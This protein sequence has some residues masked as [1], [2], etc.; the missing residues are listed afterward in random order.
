MR[1][2]PI[3]DIDLPEHPGD[4]FSLPERA[5]HYVRDVLRMR[6]G[7]PLE[8]FDGEGLLVITELI[9]VDEDGVDVRVVE[10]TRGAPGKSPL[11][12]ALYQAIPKGDRW[13]WILEKTCELGLSRVVPVESART[14][15]KVEESKQDKKLE[16]WR[17]IVAGAA[18]QSQRTVIPE[19][20]PSHS[21]K[22]AMA[23]ASFT[24]ALHLVA[25][26]HGEREDFASLWDETT[27]SSSLSLWIGPEGGWTD[28][29]VEALLDAGARPLSLGPRV[30]RTETAAITAV[31]LA[32]HLAGDLQ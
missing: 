16:Q 30:L 5:A 17:R 22:E 21:F 3:R 12:L 9:D 4:T 32:Q 8:V 20:A 7:D 14:I 25:T 23:Q 28:H 31:A 15:V 13:D 29:E 18:R 10:A 11:Q 19:V 2:V 6:V 26:P 24:E 1:R 27:S